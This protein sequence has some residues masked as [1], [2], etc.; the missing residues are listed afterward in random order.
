[1]NKLSIILAS[2]VG[3]FLIVQLLMSYKSQD[4]E[5][6]KYKVVKT[7]DSFEIRQYDTMILAQTVIKE[8][9]FK[10]S[11]STGFRKVAGYIFGGNRNKQQ[12]A[13]TAPV[14]MEFGQKKK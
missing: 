7:Y 9:S 4:I 2:A 5:T 12:I 6:P 10:K 14:I 3:V 8:T 13:M 1:M 11:G